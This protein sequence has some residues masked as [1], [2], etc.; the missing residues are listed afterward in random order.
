MLRAEDLIVDL[1][2][3]PEGLELEALLGHPAGS[4]Q[5]ELEIGCGKGRFLLAAAARW[6]ERDFLAVEQ[7]RA[8][9]GKVARRAARQALG[10][11]RFV[12]GDAK[13]LVVRALPAESLARVHVYC[14]DPW[15]KRR[16]ARRRLFS[17]PFAEDLARVLAPRGELLLTTDHDPYF[18]EVVARLAASESWV[19]CTPEEA[20]EGIPPGGFDAIFAQ[21]GVPVFRGVWQRVAPRDATAPDA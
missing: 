2:T 13:E 18:R 6:P 21:A 9:L 12:A 17:P 4:R 15:P 16:H 19:R 7:A 1:P 20:F 8:L 10:N 3:P 11:V 14:P 5:L